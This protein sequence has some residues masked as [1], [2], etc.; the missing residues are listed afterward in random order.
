MHMLD[1]V[2]Y[3]IFHS[4]AEDGVLERLLLLAASASG[5][6][7]NNSGVMSSKIA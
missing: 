6:T 1:S 7:D 2:P 3:F 4:A 5:C